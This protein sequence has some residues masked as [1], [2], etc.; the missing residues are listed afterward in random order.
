MGA[1]AL[2]WTCVSVTRD[3]GNQR[4]LELVWSRQ[5]LLR[6]EGGITPFSSR[7]WSAPGPSQSQYTPLYLSVTLQAQPWE[8]ICLTFFFLS[9][10]EVHL[11]LSKVT[12]LQL[13]EKGKLSM[14][15]LRSSIT[16]GLETSNPKA[17]SSQGIWKWLGPCYHNIVMSQKR[18]HTALLQR[19]KQ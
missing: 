6:K 7:A 16:K 14:L 8:A 5:R 17:F 12:L 3:E 18:A 13:G 15:N 11:T 4:N 9:F 19:G 10:N 2:R 1:R